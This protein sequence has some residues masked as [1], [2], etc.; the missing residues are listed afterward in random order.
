METKPPVELPVEVFS[1]ELWA[2]HQVFEAK[3]HPKSVERLKSV[4]GALKKRRTPSV[5]DELPGVTTNGDR[6]DVADVFVRDRARA[7]LGSG[8]GSLDAVDRVD[9]GLASVDDILYRPDVGD[10]LQRQNG[11]LGLARD[12]RCRDRGNSS[13]KKGNEKHGVGRD[14][15]RGKSES[16]R[17]MILAEGKESRFLK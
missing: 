12:R 13:S 5:D 1:H 15:A 17:V 11:R 4:S 8:V 2:P 14:K 3:H 9:A 6:G 7:D 16:L 10:M